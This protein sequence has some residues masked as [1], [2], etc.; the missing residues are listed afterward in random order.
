MNTAAVC[1]AQDARQSFGSGPH[2]NTENTAKYIV[3]DE[4]I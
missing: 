2:W 1:A 4:L 3:F